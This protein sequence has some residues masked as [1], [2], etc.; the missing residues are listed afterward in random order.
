MAPC[1]DRGRARGTDRMHG[2]TKSMRAA[3]TNAFTSGGLDCDSEF[4]G[5]CPIVG[6]C[7][8]SGAVQWNGTPLHDA[9]NGLGIS[10]VHD[11]GDVTIRELALCENLP[12]PP[13][14]TFIG[15][16]SDNALGQARDFTSSTAF[17]RRQPASTAKSASAPTTT[18]PPMT[19]FDSSGWKCP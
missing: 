15:G 10:A 9:L 18:K 16:S 12:C 1:W 6:V 13:P 17:K 8:G 7:P 11:I 14:K 5:P 3:Q 2:E 19:A 4:S